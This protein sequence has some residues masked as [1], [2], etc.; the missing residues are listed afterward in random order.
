MCRREKTKLS[1][2]PP[3]QGMIGTA[4]QMN[5]VADLPMMEFHTWDISRSTL[6]LKR[7][8][9]IAVATVGLFLLAP[10]FV[11]IPSQFV[12]IRAER[13]SSCRPAWAGMVACSACTSSGRWCGMRRR[14]SATSSLSTLSSAR[15]SSFVGPARDPLRSFSPRT[16]LDELP[17]LVNVVKGDMSLVGRDRNRSSSSSATTRETVFVSS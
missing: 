7:S 17:Q 13:S 2:I 8:L 14:S 4:V 5:H 6:L 11:L 1:V 10:L 16:S 15:C 3:A 9:D 12:S